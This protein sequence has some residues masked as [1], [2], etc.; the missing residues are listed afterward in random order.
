[1]RIDIV[2]SGKGATAELHD[3][4]NFQLELSAI[5][6]HMSRDVALLLSRLHAHERMLNPRWPTA[7]YILELIE[8]YQIS[9]GWVLLYV[10]WNTAEKVSAS[11]WARVCGYVLT[12]GDLDCLLGVPES[13]R[14][15]D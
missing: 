13:E 8:R 15:R 7:N 10:Y 5:Y 3:I 1:M 6:R 11:M 9:S 14:R 12:R 2:S 4:G